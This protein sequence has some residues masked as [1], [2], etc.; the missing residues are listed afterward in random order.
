MFIFQNWLQD[1]CQESFKCSFFSWMAHDANLGTPVD[2]GTLVMMS[3][4]LHRN[5][6]VYTFSKEIPLWK[7]NSEIGDDISLLYCGDN[8][9][10]EA[11]VGT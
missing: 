9:F 8:R 7:V 1:Y 6:T 11:Q 4:L 2:G 5:I 10:V 3:L